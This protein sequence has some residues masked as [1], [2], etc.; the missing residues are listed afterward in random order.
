[1]TI[2]S[3]CGKD[4][5]GPLIPFADVSVSVCLNCVIRKL[6]KIDKE[7]MYHLFVIIG[8]NISEDDTDA[9]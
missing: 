3:V 7:W 4:G 8:N 2:C 1:M 6:K 9:D 5:Q